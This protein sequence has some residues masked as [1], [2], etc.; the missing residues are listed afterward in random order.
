[1]PLGQ[2]I[3]TLAPEAAL[4]IQ[5]ELGITQQDLANLTA[6]DSGPFQGPDAQL[7]VTVAATQ[8]GDDAA[9]PKT[10]IREIWL[11]NHAVLGPLQARLPVWNAAYTNLRK[12]QVASALVPEFFR[13]ITENVNGVRRVTHRGALDPADPWP[14]GHLV[15][16]LTHTYHGLAWPDNGNPGEGFFV[17]VCELA[18]ATLYHHA[19]MAALSGGAVRCGITRTFICDL[20]D[21]NRP[22]AVWVFDGG[23]GAGGC[24]DT[25]W[26]WRLHLFPL[27]AGPDGFQFDTDRD[28]AFT[29]THGA[30]M[31]AGGNVIRIC[32]AMSK[33]AARVD[34]MVWWACQLYHHARRTGSIWYMFMAILCTRNAVSDI[35]R[36]ASVLLHEIGHVASAGLGVGGGPHCGNACCQDRAEFFFQ[37]ATWAAYGLPEDSGVADRFSTE[38][39]TSNGSGSTGCGGN[40]FSISAEHCALL[41]ARHAV[42]H[43]VHVDASC[44]GVDVNE[45]YQFFTPACP[46]P[47]MQGTDSICW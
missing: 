21:G 2:D 36:I 15:D 16:N 26:D 42:H 25:A 44:G 8:Q 1:M 7:D 22:E 13:A 32:G 6:D 5:N 27:P 4:I 47:Q 11:G 9:L 23:P 19:D 45:D 24:S 30:N 43:V 28:P 40:V 37:H 3:L 46:F 35:V 33:R 39:W 31:A 34:Y 18:A 41:R 12:R 38:N 10:Q 17:K 29:G 14:R 20:I